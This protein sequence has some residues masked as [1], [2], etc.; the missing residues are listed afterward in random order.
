MDRQPRLPAPKGPFLAGWLLVASSLSTR[1]E[2]GDRA[3]APEGREQAG[4]RIGASPR[5]PATETLSMQGS[6]SDTIRPSERVEIGCS[7]ELEMT[8]ELIF[9]GPGLILASRRSWPM[10]A[11]LSPQKHTASFSLGTLLKSTRSACYRTLSLSAMHALN[12]LLAGPTN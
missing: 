11:Q 3:G 6:W 1:P 9:R 2:S 12:P 5:P 10:L 8:P 7:Q 4:A